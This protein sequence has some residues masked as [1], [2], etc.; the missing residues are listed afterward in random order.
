MYVK[1]VSTCT[2]YDILVA[3]HNI[4]IVESFTALYSIPDA[5]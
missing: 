4:V 3:L 2:C 5:G 1:Y